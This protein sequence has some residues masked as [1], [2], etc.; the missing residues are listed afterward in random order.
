M[1]WGGRIRELYCGKKNFGMSG[2]NQFV[3]KELSIENVSVF[4]LTQSHF[5]ILK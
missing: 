4:G 3:T 2:Q 1:F 5:K